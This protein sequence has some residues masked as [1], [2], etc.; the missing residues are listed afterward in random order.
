M[1]ESKTVVMGKG[2]RQRVAGVVVNRKPNVD[3]AAYDVLRATLHN[4]AH[5]GLDA[6]NRGDHPRF[7]E[8]LAGRVA[9][10]VSLNATRKRVLLPL[11]RGANT[12]P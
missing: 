9:W 10:A 4:V 7:A 1:N 12:Q 2:Q 5:N 11:P 8:H 3:R 6:E